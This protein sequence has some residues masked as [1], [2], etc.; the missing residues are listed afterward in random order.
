MICLIC[1]WC[2]GGQ[3]K[4][5]SNLISNKLGSTVNMKLQHLFKWLLQKVQIESIQYKTWFCENKIWIISIHKGK[6]YCKL[7]VAF[8]YKKSKNPE[9]NPSKCY[10]SHKW[11]WFI[12]N[13]DFKNSTNNKGTNNK[14]E[15]STKIKSHC[16]GWRVYELQNNKCKYCAP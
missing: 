1:L 8:C 3:T 9:R 6:Y 12:P 13:I 7:Y 2:Y 15:K 16:E 14:A 4:T 11:T 5:S 10:S